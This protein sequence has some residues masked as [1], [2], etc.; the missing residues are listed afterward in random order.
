MWSG[1]NRRRFP[2]ANYRCLITIRKRGIRSRFLTHTENIGVGG[3]AVAVDKDLGIFSEVEIELVLKEQTL[4]IR[5][6]GTVVWVVK[7]GAIKKGRPI[8]KFDTGI[9]FVDIKESD[10]ARIE[11]V[12][13]GIIQ[14]E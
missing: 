3:I 2:R 7:S 6:K 14:K 13:E 10:R 11:K 1:I 5:C 4:P 9:E 8:T 12:V